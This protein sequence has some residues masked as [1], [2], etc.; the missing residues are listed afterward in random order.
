MDVGRSGE[1]LYII[2]LNGFNSSGFYAA[3]LDA[4][5][6]AIAAGPVARA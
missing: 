4:L 2:E 1:N 6:S 5:V 3:R